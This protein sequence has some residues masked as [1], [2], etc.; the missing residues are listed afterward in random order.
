MSDLTCPACNSSK[1]QTVKVVRTH[2]APL[3]RPKNYTADVNTC[4]ECGEEGDFNS[5]NSKEMKIAYLASGVELVRE[6]IS[7]LRKHDMSPAFLDRVLGLERGTIAKWESGVD[8]PRE[9][10][11]IMQ[12]LKAFP[13]IAEAAEEGYT[14]EAVARVIRSYLLL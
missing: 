13:W 2:R 11:P 5:E 9:A 1:I 7:E 6:T 8:V 12:F 10:I 14:H 3:G 4:L